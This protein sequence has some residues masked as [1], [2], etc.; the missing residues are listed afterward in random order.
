MYVITAVNICEKITF[1]LKKSRALESLKLCHNG[2][3]SVVCIDT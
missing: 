2:E 1:L 3:R